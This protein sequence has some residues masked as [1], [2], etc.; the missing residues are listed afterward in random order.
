MQMVTLVSRIGKGVCKKRLRLALPCEAVLG[1]S[2]FA[3]QEPRLD[4]VVWM[5][6]AG[7]SLK[8]GIAC[9]LHQGEQHPHSRQS[10][11]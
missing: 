6:L 10:T 3:L 4:Q 1:L 2:G 7:L 8:S 11:R 5:N 9:A